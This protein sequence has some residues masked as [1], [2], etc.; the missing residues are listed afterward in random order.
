[1]MLQ[2]GDNP[3]SHRFT[4]SPYFLTINSQKRLI[5]SLSFHNPLRLCPQSKVECRKESL[6]TSKSVEVKGPKE[7]NQFY[8]CGEES[9]RQG[10]FVEQKEPPTGNGVPTGVEDTR[11]RYGSQRSGDEEIKRSTPPFNGK[12]FSLCI[13]VYSLS[14]Q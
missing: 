1:M 9:L 10:T 13:F 11:S 4:Y 2:R 8:T 7:E 6:L 12:H 14:F 5:P 3:I